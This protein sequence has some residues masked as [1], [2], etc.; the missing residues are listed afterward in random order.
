[1][2]VS[3][4]NAIIGIANF[5]GQAFYSCKVGDDDDGHFY[6]NGLD[7]AGVHHHTDKRHLK[8]DTGTCLVMITP[9][10]ERTLCTFFGTNATLSKDDLVPEVIAAAEYVY[11]ETYML[12]SPGTQAAAVRLRQIAEQNGVKTALSFSDA[13]IVKEFRD[14]LSV[15]LS[16]PVDLL[17]CNRYEAQ[18]WAE[19]E[20]IEI[21]IESL[22][23][24]A[25]TFVITL[26]KEGALVYDGTQV[27]HIAPNKVKATN[28]NGA[29]DSF[30]GGVFIRYYTR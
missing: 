23:K 19:T 11:F 17:F 12:M 30:A 6:L 16:K 15:I 1:M 24:I 29:G 28:T 10:A 8:G 13:G 22:K 20:N 14:N 27:H 3:T 7:E 5:G 21:V 18:T 25:H 26:G 9:D 2:V 4:A